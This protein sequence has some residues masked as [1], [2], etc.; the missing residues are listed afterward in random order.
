MGNAAFPKSPNRK[1]RN[2]Q[3]CGGM[4]ME[5]RSGVDR[6]FSVFHLNDFKVFASSEGISTRVVFIYDRHENKREF[7]LLNKKIPEDLAVE[8]RAWLMEH[9]DID[10]IP[11]ALG[12]EEPARQLKVQ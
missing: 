2:E 5:R 9:V 6:L 7:K 4:W 12:T 3:F 11:H 1:S 10:E 8:I